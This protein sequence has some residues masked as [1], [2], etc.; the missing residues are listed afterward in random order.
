MPAAEALLA[1]S[2]SATPLMAPRPNSS[3]ML[4][5]LPL[6]G[7]GEKGRDLG[8]AA[9]NGLDGR[10]KA[11]PR[12]HGLQDSSQASRVI[13]SD[14]FVGKSRPSAMLVVE[15]CDLAASQRTRVGS[16]RLHP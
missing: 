5:Q 12:S 6:G 14:A 4:C 11:A 10:P 9:R 2:G 13:R 1:A 8:A 15:M 16:A 7:I 3:G